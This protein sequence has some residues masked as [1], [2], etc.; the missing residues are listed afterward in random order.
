[1]SSNDQFNILGSSK[2]NTADGKNPVASGSGTAESKDLASGPASAASPK[3][4]HHS[5]HDAL[6]DRLREEER[7]ARM[8]GHPE[9]LIDALSLIGFRL[10]EGMIV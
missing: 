4:E 5:A 2:L 8:F 3:N 10:E 7:L 1:M 6:E 9:F